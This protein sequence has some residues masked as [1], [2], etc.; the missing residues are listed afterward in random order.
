[1]V[2]MDTQLAPADLTEQAGL[3]DGWRL[4]QLPSPDGDHFDLVDAATPSLAFSY[5]FDDDMLT[6]R[7]FVGMDAH[8]FLPLTFDPEHRAFSAVADDELLAVATQVGEWLWD[9]RERRTAALA[10][11]PA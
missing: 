6:L 10:S 8:E 7:V 5:R 2:L 3:P 4:T 11:A 9:R 1:M